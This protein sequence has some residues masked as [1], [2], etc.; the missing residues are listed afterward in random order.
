MKKLVKIMSLVLAL[1]LVFSL[2]GCGNNKNENVLTMATNAEFPPFE[3][4]EGETIVGADVDI[5]NAIAEKLGKT[6][7]ITNIDFDAALTGAA[8]GKYDVA[9]AGVTATDERRQNMGFTDDYYTASQ[10]IIVTS[11]STIKA[12]ADL[13]GK[14]ISCQ[15]GTTGEQYLLDNSYSVQSFKT[16]A[17]AITALVSG[18]VD[19]VVIDDAVARALS[20]KQDGKTVVLDEALTEEAYAIVTKLGNNALIAEINAAL[21]DLKEEG[22]LAEIFEKYELPYDAE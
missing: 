17:E 3:Y 19:A 1:C 20:K 9:I 13:E 10:A 2:A 21:A 8:T 18:K 14:T 12:A 11:D 15:E 6:L 5:A 4:L 16:G 7:E 22:K